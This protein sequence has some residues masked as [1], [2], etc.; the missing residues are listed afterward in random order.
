MRTHPALAIRGVEIG[1]TLGILTTI[2]NDLAYILFIY[3]DMFYFK[4][5]SIIN[6]ISLRDH[7]IKGDWV[8]QKCEEF[9]DVVCLERGSCRFQIVYGYF[10]GYFWLL[11]LSVQQI[12]GSG[13]V[14][15]ANGKR[16]LDS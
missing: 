1:Y 13:K 7:N 14:A 16:W 11:Q 9:A 10:P 8:R 15:I 3:N 4:S 6:L 2:G 5:Y 12:G